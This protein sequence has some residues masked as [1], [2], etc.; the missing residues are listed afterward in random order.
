MQ[1][2][3]TEQKPGPVNPAPQRLCYFPSCLDVADSPRPYGCT[4]C[5]LVHLQAKPC[6]I[7]VYGYYPENRI[8]YHTVKLTVD[9]MVKE[10]PLG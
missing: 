7:H 10:P 4:A 3:R 5:S 6:A 1:V 9:F 2:V 8:S